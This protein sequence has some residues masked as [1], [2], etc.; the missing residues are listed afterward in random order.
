MGE[1]KN[2]YLG[3]GEAPTG[4]RKISREEMLRGL[5]GPANIF[6]ESGFG[7]RED[8]LNNMRVKGIRF[9]NVVEL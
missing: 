2:I 5:M 8:T 7:V 1:I 9:F 4:F 6:V 3:L